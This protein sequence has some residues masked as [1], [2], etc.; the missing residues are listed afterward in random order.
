MSDFTPIRPGSSVGYRVDLRGCWIWTG[1][2]SWNGYGRVGVPLQRK[3]VGAH[4]V[5]FEQANGPIPP[6]MDLDHLCRNRACVNPKHLEPVPRHVNAWRGERTKLTP[7]QVREI[8]ALPRPRR[9]GDL[10]R[11]AERYSCHAK[12]ISDIL[13][14]ENWKS[15]DGPCGIVPL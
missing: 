9:R 12:T 15:L 4:R 13:T 8:R 10:S 6:G 7:E 14:G 2:L 3:T 5:Y 11:I 1:A